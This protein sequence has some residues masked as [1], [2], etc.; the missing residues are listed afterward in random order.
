MTLFTR[1]GIST[2]RESYILLPTPLP[3]LFYHRRFAP[4]LYREWRQ[5]FLLGLDVVKQREHVFRV[6]VLG[7][8]GVYKDASDACALDFDR[9]GG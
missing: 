7:E 6:L 3:T 4:L 2:H 9:L 1:S 8:E 5:I